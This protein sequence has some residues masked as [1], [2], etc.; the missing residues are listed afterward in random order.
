[1]KFVVAVMGP[2]GVGK[3]TLAKRLGR[4]MDV[5]IIGMSDIIRDNLHKIPWYEEKMNQGILLDDDHCIRFWMERMNQMPILDGM[6]LDGFP[7]TMPQLNQFRMQFDRRRWHHHAHFVFM[8]GEKFTCENRVLSRA[9]QEGRADD[10]RE[11]FNSRWSAWMDHG[12][13]IPF[14][15]KQRL[16]MHGGVTWQEVDA[17]YTPD[18]IYYMVASRLPQSIAIERPA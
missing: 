14:H 2:P 10:T 11:V 18:E 15:V 16:C 3:G 7:R 13:L 1:M 9:I 4:D 5:P 17:N 8:K 6:V 12:R